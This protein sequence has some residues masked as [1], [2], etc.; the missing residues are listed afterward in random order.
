MNDTDP[1]DEE[2]RIGIFPS[3]A[4][5]YATVVVYTTALIVLLYVFTIV[6]DFSAQ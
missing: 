4:A 6:L 3:W 1:E 2:G 5:L